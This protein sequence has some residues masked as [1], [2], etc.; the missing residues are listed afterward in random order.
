MLFNP[1]TAPKCP[2]ISSFSGNL[3][4]LPLW[5]TWNPTRDCGSSTEATPAV[6]HM[7]EATYLACYWLFRKTLAVPHWY[8]RGRAPILV[9]D[10]VAPLRPCCGKTRQPKKLSSI[11]I[12]QSRISG[13]LLSS[14]FYF[15]CSLCKSEILYKLE[16]A[17]C[18]ILKV[19][20]CS[21]WHNIC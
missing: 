1:S 9:P 5:A 6:V 19:N 14:L 20:Y 17:K 13:N 18:D 3:T 4:Q 11:L 8:Q 15:K 7:S 10:P 21:V 2:L 12:A 16:N